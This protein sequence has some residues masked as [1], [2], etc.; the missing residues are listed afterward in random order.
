MSISS[1]EKRPLPDARRQ[2]DLAGEIGSQ[3]VDPANQVRR[4]A[5]PCSAAASEK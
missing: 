5:W 4:L 3:P 1:D 2:I